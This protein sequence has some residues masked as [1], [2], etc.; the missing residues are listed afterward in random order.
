MEINIIRGLALIGLIV[1]FIGIF[2]WAWSKKRKPD[3]ERAAR[4]PLEED[5]P[6]EAPDPEKTPSEQDTEK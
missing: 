1:G 4:A 6:A 5:A 3:F 2:I